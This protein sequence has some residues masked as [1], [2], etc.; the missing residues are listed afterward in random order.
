MNVETHINPTYTLNLTQDEY[1][2]VIVAIFSSSKENINKL[3]KHG[4]FSSQ[5]INNMDRELY[6]L[7]EKFQQIYK[8]ETLI[9]IIKTI[10]LNGLNIKGEELK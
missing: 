4:Y 6:N 9:D 3:Y 8:K 7:A 1:V 5:A 2:A 10:K